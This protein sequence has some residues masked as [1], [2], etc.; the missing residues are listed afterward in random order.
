MFC[1]PKKKWLTLGARDFSCAVSGFGQKKDYSNPLVI[2][3][4]RHRSIQ[5]HAGKNFWYPGQKWLGFHTSD[6]FGV[7]STEKSWGR[8][9]LTMYKA[10]IKNL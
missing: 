3:C 2:Y 5:P 4:S 1:Y 10:M 9:P 7:V 8:K 6:L